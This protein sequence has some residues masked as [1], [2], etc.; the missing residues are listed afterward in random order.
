MHR[1]PFGTPFLGTSICGFM[2]EVFPWG[3]YRTSARPTCSRESAVQ[4]VFLGYLA[5]QTNRRRFA[6]RL[7]GQ[8]S[9]GS[10]WHANERSGASC[11]V[12][13]K[14]G[15][16]SPIQTGT[17]LALDEAF[18]EPAR[19]RSG[20]P[21]LHEPLGQHPN[22]PPSDSGA[23]GGAGTERGTGR[24]KGQSAPCRART[25]A[26]ASELSCFTFEKSPSANSAGFTTQVPPAAMI[27]GSDR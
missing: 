16:R 1:V 7:V 3:S 11:E 24:S 26:A 17:A 21:A 18:V 4:V 20:S 12:A 6:A 14:A 13:P 2:S 22:C 25:M 23:V 8:R 10:P 15:H 9:S 5:G 19:H 27:T